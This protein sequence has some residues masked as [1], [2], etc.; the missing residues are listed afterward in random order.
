MIVRIINNLASN[1]ID[2]HIDCDQISIKPEFNQNENVEKAKRTVERI[3]ISWKKSGK[4]F[5]D[6]LKAEVGLSIYVI[7]DV[8]KTVSRYNVTLNYRWDA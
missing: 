6:I 1:T 2:K 3:F 7:N 4:E 8:G 5:K